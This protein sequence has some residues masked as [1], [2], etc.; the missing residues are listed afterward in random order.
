MRTAKPHS[1]GYPAAYVSPRIASF[2]KKPARPGNARDRERRD[3]HREERVR[4]ELPEAPHLR[5]VLLARESVDD[6][7]G[8][9]EE[10]GLEPRVREDV[11]HARRER[12]NAA[13]EEHVAEL[14]DRG[15]REDLLDVVLGEA[16]RRG[17]ESGRAPDDGDD[18]GGVVR[19]E[20]AGRRVTVRRLHRPDVRDAE[21]E[22]AA[23]DHVDAGRDH[24]G[25]VDER[26]D[27]RRAGHRV[28]KPHVERNLGALAARP[29]EEAQADRRQEPPGRVAA[30]IAPRRARTSCRSPRCRRARSTRRCPGRTRSRRCGSRRTPSCR[31]PRRRSSSSRTRSGGTSRARR[32]PSPRTGSAGSLRGRA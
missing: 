16:H 5:H 10:A 26:R 6:G 11:E 12:E 1:T 27:G 29:D 3:E 2:E 8:A 4:D 28:R 15:V 14:R 17:E 9:E 32:L 19:E 24:R 30:R 13:A 23:R 20:P 21:E 18:E 7:A 22:V 31:R 25:R